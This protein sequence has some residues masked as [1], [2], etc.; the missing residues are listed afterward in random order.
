M[1]TTGEGLKNMKILWTSIRDAP[2]L[3]EVTHGTSETKLCDC[4]ARS[5]F[6]NLVAAPMCTRLLR[7][8]PYHSDGSNSNESSNSQEDRSNS[9]GDREPC[10]SDKVAAAAA[11]TMPLVL[12]LI[13]RR[14]WQQSGEGE[15]SPP[16]SL[17]AVLA[18]GWMVAW[19]LSLSCS[20]KKAVGA[21]DAGSLTING[22]LEK[23]TVQERADGELTVAL[24]AQLRPNKNSGNR[25]S[26]SPNFSTS[27]CPARSQLFRNS[28]SLSRKGH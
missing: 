18:V 28:P 21:S 15:V 19:Y 25:T 8:C 22:I 7:V 10:V 23:R 24:R 16:N 11:V 5:D 4:S 27:T 20:A 13:G 12:S 3:S 9:V 14:R 17:V 26:Q 2:N 6:I 1:Q